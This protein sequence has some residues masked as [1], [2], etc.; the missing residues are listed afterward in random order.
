M[1]KIIIC[2]LQ[3]TKSV[4]SNNI[5]LET[6]MFLRA[7]VQGVHVLLLVDTGATLT[8]VSNEVAGR[9]GKEL[10][11]NLVRKSVYDAGGKKLNVSGRGTFALSIDSF[12][13]TVHAAVADLT[14]D[15]ILGL[16]FLTE[17]N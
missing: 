3:K 8:I 4:G 11:P 12:S 9:I 15:G 2:A 17:Y 1:F 14:V 7:N 13:C 5:G 10:M 16:D 6:G